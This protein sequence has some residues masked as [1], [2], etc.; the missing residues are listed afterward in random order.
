MESVIKRDGKVCKYDA[1]KIFNA[2]KSAFMAVDG[3][4]TTKA[5]EIAKLAIQRVEAQQKSLSVED[6]QD[7]VED[8]L[9]DSSRKD[10]ARAYVR[11]RFKHEVLRK[12]NTTDHTLL[13]LLKGE[14][15]YWN[16]ENANKNAKVVHT[17]RDYFAGITSTDITRRFLLPPEIVDAHDKGII[18]FHDCDYFAQ[19]ALHNCELINLE[20]ML[21]NGTVV[22][23]VM[24]EKPHRL[25][26]AATIATQIILAVASSSYGG[27]TVSLT[28][29][30]PFVRDSKNRYRERYSKSDLREDTVE[31]AEGC[32]KGL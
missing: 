30:A 29:L 24:I 6:I 18:H 14:N 32:E 15:D 21:Q 10:V 23:G 5:E 7:I 4:F 31:S 12:E 19:N 9:M 16:T 25:I 11:Y 1:N 26:T 8:T 13:S 22:N 2:I 17:Q 27:A 20:D 3:A 28:H